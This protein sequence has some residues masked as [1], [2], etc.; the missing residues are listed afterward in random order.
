MAFPSLL[1]PGGTGLD[2]GCGMGEPMAARMLARGRV[3]RH[4]GGDP[5]CGGRTVWLA[6]R[7]DIE[8]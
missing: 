6:Q 5:A 8:E 2:P 3:M 4:V 1:P 7:K